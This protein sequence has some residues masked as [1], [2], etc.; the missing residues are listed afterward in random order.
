MY[1]TCKKTRVLSEIL[2]SKKKDKEQIH[3]DVEPRTQVCHFYIPNTHNY[4]RL[5]DE[6]TAEWWLCGVLPSDGSM[7]LGEQAVH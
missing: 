1:T 6:G 5:S 7:S 2:K 3:K 4:L